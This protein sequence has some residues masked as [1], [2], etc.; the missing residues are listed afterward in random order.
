M[1]LKKFNEDLF[2]TTAEQF[3]QHYIN[4]IKDKIDQLKRDMNYTKQGKSYYDKIQIKI[5]VLEDLL[6]DFEDPHYGDWM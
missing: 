4:I 6:S 2:D 5:D 3:K 1:R